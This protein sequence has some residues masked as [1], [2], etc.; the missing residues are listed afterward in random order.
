MVGSLVAAAAWA[1]CY[2]NLWRLFKHDFAGFVYD[3]AARLPGV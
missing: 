2:Q 3:L 1:A